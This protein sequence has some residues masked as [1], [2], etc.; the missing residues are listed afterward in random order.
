MCD[1]R[2]QECPVNGKRL[3]QNLIYKATAKTENQTKFYICFTGLTFKDRY[4]GISLNMKNIEMRQLY[5]SVF[6]NSNTTK[7]TFKFT[8]KY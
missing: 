6:G 1:C 7:L 8:G 3:T 2:K 5:H 4:T